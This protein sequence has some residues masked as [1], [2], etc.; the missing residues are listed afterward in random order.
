MSLRFVTKS[1]HAYLDYPVAFALIGLPF[2]LGLG[3]ANPLALWLS[4]GTG[5]AALILTLLTDHQ[6][7]VLRVLPYSLHLA[8]DGAVGALFL[9]APFLFGFTGL[10]AAYYFAN[11]L[12]VAIVVSLHK[13]ETEMA[14]A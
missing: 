11:G 3:A 14:T 2:I 13:P 9:L 7:G 1:I 4:V 5:A 8:V 12:A 10:D 6:F